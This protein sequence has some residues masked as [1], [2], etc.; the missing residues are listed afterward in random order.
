M[1]LYR[2][3]G[4]PGILPGSLFLSLYIS[5]LVSSAVLVAWISLSLPLAPFT[6]I[7]LSVEQVRDVNSGRGRGRYSS[8][9]SVI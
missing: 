9:I 8:I 5:Y 3:P 2:R 1:W 6:V 7:I 4:I